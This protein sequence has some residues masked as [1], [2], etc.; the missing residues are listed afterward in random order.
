MTEHECEMKIDESGTVCGLPAHNVI[1]SVKLQMWLCP[2]HFDF[3]AELW[4]K[5][6]KWPD[7]LGMVGRII[8]KRNKL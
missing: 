2:E 4:R 3:W 1:K 5:V 7:E 6:S 8:V